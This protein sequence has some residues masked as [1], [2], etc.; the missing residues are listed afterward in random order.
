VN[1]RAIAEGDLL[2][3]HRDVSSVGY[4]AHRD[5]EVLR[6]T[7]QRVRVRYYDDGGSH[8]TTVRSKF[9]FPRDAACERCKALKEPQWEPGKGSRRLE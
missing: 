2:T 7:A 6:V 9:L 1:I 8:E 4:I 5:V 3:L